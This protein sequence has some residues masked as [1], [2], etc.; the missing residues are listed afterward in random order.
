M[1]QLLVS[2]T[3]SDAD[4]TAE[5]L[6]GSPEGAVLVSWENDKGRN[7]RVS[8]VILLGDPA[9]DQL[10]QNAAAFDILIALT[11]GVNP[12]YGKVVQESKALDSRLRHPIFVDSIAVPDG[13]TLEIWVKSS[14]VNDNQVDGFVYLYDLQSGIDVRAVGG[15][16][17][18]SKADINAEVD[19]ALS[20]AKL[21]KAAKLLTNKAVQNKSTGAID[22]YDDDGETVVLTH[23]P[24]DVESTITRTPS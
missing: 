14:N 21:D 13:M 3:F 22:Y 4:L 24:T 10:D 9:G 8:A 20:D 6:K 16:T 11:D 2:N 17:P 12:Y 1:N 15:G 18:I 7:V 19:T 5:S 23:T